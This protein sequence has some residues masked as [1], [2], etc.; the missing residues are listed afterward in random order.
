MNI[1]LI[2][3]PTEKEYLSVLEVLH[4][5]DICWT[6]GNPLDPEKDRAWQCYGDT[7]VV[8]VVKNAYPRHHPCRLQ[9]CCRSWWLT[10]TPNATIF[11]TQ[12]FM[13]R[14]QKFLPFIRGE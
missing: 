4:S 3:T 1:L 8:A 11:S 9:Y 10:T 12:E 5:D 13:S 6:T 14:H 7:T 2:A